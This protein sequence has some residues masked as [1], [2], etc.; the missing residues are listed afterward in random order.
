[1]FLFWEIY[2]DSTWSKFAQT[3]ILNHYQ[4][5]SKISLYMYISYSNIYILTF[6]EFMSVQ[7]HFNYLQAKLLHWISMYNVASTILYPI[8][9]YF[10]FGKLDHINGQT[11]LPYMGTLV[12]YSHFICFTSNSTFICFNNI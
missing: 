5:V 8:K 4:F 1:M 3:S 12:N 9:Y 2:A 7:R 6:M 11:R 10:C